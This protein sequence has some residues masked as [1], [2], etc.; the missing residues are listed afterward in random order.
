MTLEKARLL[1]LTTL[2]NC[3]LSATVWAQQNNELEDLDDDPIVAALDSLYKLDLFEKG[4]QKVQYK[5]Q[6]V[7]HYAPDSVPRCSEEEYAARLK[8]LDA[9]SPFDLRYNNV[10]K[11]YIDMYA[12]RKRE[13]V[14][15]MMAL[16]QLYFPMFEEVLDRHNLP[17]EFKYLAICESALNPIA[18]SRAGAAGLW[19][20]M[21]PT[22]KM[23]GL[24]VNS[25]IDE[26]HDPYKSTEAACE[27]FEYLY[28]L[29]HNWE[30]VLAAYNCGPG[31]VNKAIRRSGG[32]KTYWEIRP[33]LPKE[34]RGYV[35]AFI[36]VNYV[37][38][39]TAEHN[40]QSAAPKQYFSQVDTVTIQQQVSFYLL[41]DLLEMSEDEIQ[42]LNPSY[43][44][45]VIPVYPGYTSIL[46]LPSEKMGIFVSNEEK[47][48]EHY[49]ISK[50]AEA[51]V[52][53]EEPVENHPNGKTLKI[54]TIRSGDNLGHIAQKFGCNVN[55]I[56]RWNNLYSNKIYVGK[57][58][59][60]YVQ[61]YSATNTTPSKPAENKA[62]NS[63]TKADGYKYHTIQKGDSL[64]KI[65]MQYNT[66]IEHLKRLNNLGSKYN[67][68]PGQLIKVGTM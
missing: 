19:Q 59:K 55:D 34:T 15:R 23:F 58:L 60:I 48:Y 13:I 35:P 33:Y 38:N 51:V 49:K 32:K 17:L 45:R 36:A 56:K 20:F 62:D 47:I 3:F 65:A 7:Y 64:Y 67:L 21:Y 42:F 18:R 54:Y 68:L 57:K 41:A 29:Y 43:K 39:Y 26:R 5:D 46:T 22:G 6:S 1:F 31:N 61:S 4:Y 11:G 24:K 30:L 63:I 66:T 10:V 27:Y 50:P 2:L 28:D 8:K 14:S 52:V 9:K 53:K 44:R 40:I 37:M 16:S 25:Y 12:I